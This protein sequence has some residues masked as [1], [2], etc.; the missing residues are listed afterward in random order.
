MKDEA[1]A[2]AKAHRFNSDIELEV[3]VFTKGAAYW[4]RMYNDLECEQLLSP[5]DRDFVKSISS[6]ISRGSLPTKMQIKRLFKII[7]KAE[8]EGYIMPE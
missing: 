8:D 6:Y 5:G 1:K 2:A 7:T 4:M 3:G